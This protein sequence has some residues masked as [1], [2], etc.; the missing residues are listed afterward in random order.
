MEYSN[1]PSD[2][3]LLMSLWSETLKGYRRLTECAD[4]MTSNVPFAVTQA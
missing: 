4:I 1:L 3:H 2:R